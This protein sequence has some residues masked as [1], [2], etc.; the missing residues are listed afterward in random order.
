MPKYYIRNTKCGVETVYK[1]IGQRWKPWILHL[2]YQKD[3]CTFSELQEELK[4]ITNTELTGKLSSLSADDL[5]IRVA[6]SQ[7]RSKHVYKV[8]AKTIELT[9]ILSEMHRFS[10]N[11]GYTPDGLSSAIEYSKS[12]IGNKWRS[13]VIWVLHNNG[14]TRFNE[15]QNSIEGLTHKVLTNI[16]NDFEERGLIISIDF[17]EKRPHVEYCL[18][19]LG[20]DAYELIEKAAD[21]CIKY[22]IIA[23]RIIIEN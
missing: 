6:S 7:D 15:M 11:A 14:M 2:C 19:E 12:L 3:G 1:M 16:L 10:V 4:D 17:H 22:N 20:E 13:R 8:T 23:P 21:F 9:E 5:L 18:T